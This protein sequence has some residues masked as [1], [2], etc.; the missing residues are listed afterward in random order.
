M[1]LTIE[2]FDTYSIAHLKRPLETV[3]AILTADLHRTNDPHRQA[4]QL[5]YADALLSGAGDLDREAFLDRVN[6]LGAS[7]DI[8]VRG[9]KVTIGLKATAQQFSKLMKLVELMLEKP[10]FKSAELKRI[11]ATTTNELHDSKEN[12]KAIAL[13]ELQN[14]FYGQADR[15]YNYEAD[16]LIKVVKVISARELK[17]LHRTL[18][19]R[20]WHVSVASADAGLKTLQ[21]SLKRLKGQ[22]ALTPTDAI[23][24]PL[25]ANPALALREIPS[26]QNVDFSIGVPLPIT[27]QHPDFLA[28]HFGIA[29]LAKWGGFA[30]RLM[31]TVREKEGLTYSIYGRLEGFGGDEQGYLRIFT[32][33]APEKAVQGLDATFREVIKWY[34]KGV[35][36]AEFLTFKTILS[37]QQTMLQDSTRRLL[38]DLHSYH[39]QGFTIPEMEAHK[40]RLHELTLDEVNEAIKTHMDPSY[41]SVSGAG[42]VK[43]IQNELRQWHRDVA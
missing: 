39:C 32:F 11:K 8:S 19:S 1:S 38:D 34:E 12:S 13:E 17:E 36:E 26:R 27:F 22:T 21:Q 42:P 29:V 14:I 23:H 10:A 4:A 3:E 31:S 35:S 16:E 5:M 18:F 33:F 28:L 40:Q 43:A 15:R 20:P 6:G 30:G 25:P 37:T 41:F 2:R 9:G 24:Q 7:I